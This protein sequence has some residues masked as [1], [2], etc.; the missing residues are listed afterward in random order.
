MLLSLHIRQ[1]V[2]KKMMIQPVFIAVI[3]FHTQ[4]PTKA[5]YNVLLVPDGRTMLVLVCGKTAKRLRPVC[6]DVET[7]I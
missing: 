2:P 4:S 5:G 1:S 7:E 6:L 3:H